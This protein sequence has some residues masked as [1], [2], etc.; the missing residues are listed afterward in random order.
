MLPPPGFRWQIEA[1]QLV[2]ILGNSL[3]DIL[4]AVFFRQ[5][6]DLVVE[7][8][9]E[10]LEEEERQQVV[11]ELGRVLLAANGA[12]GIPKHLLHGLGGWFG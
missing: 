10:A 8:V 2:V 7:D 12:R 4:I 11:L 1:Q 5:P 3:C 6:L 9:R